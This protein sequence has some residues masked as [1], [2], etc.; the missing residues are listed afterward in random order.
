M[1]PSKNGN[2]IFQCINKDNG[3]PVNVYNV[4]NDK[5]GYPQFL[6]YDNGIW[7]YKSAKFFS[8]KGKSRIT[9][10]QKLN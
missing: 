2:F 7:Y 1:F 4:R 10:W 6:I 8:V 3:K 5:N 9:K